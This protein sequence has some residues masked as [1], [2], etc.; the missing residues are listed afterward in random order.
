LAIPDIPPF[1]DIEDERALTQAIVD[2][3]REP[4]LVLD[5]DLR[6]VLAGRSFYILFKKESQD[7][8][9]IASPPHA[10]PH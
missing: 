4:L 9:S 5:K 10:P 2:T 6:V 7:A 3:I 1:G 8:R